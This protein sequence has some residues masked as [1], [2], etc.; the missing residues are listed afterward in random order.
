MSEL[1][2]VL[3]FCG[4]MIAL[5]MAA[6]G[7]SLCAVTTCAT[8]AEEELA[9][10]REMGRRSKLGTISYISPSPNFGGNAHQRRIARRAS[11]RANKLQSD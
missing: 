4:V 3:E 1:V 8:R 2:K 5:A 11:A 10:A 6:L 9:K 7:W